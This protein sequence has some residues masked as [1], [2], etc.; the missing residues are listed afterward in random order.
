MAIR[1]LIVAIENYP[2]ASGLAKEL[3]GTNDAARSF[4]NWLAEKKGVQPKGKPGYNRSTFFC[5]ADK[6]VDF[7]TH[8]TTRD[9]IVRAVV[10]LENAAKEDLASGVA[11][12]D[13]LYCFFSGHGLC[14]P[15]NETVQ[16]DLFIASDF[17]TMR[18]S[19]GA[20]VKVTELMDLLRPALGPGDHYYFFDYSRTEV[21]FGEVTPKG[22]GLVF[23]RVQAKLPSVAVLFSVA[24]GLA[25][26]T[27]SGFAKHLVD[28]LSGKGRAKG[29]Y[30][31]DLYV[32]FGFLRE[33]LNRATRNGV[34][35][36]AGSG[37]GLILKI[38]PVPTAPC[39]IKVLDAEPSDYF[40]FTVKQRNKLIVAG[41]FNG[42]EHTVV[43]D[44]PGDY[45]VEVTHR[46]AAVLRVMPPATSLVDLYDA[47]EVVFRKV[48]SR[49]VSPAI[50]GESQVDSKPGI[51]QVVV[52]P[53]AA[54]LERI[55]LPDTALVDA[56]E[57]PDVPF[58]TIP[59]DQESHGT[60]PAAAGSQKVKTTPGATIR[61]QRM[62]A[63]ANEPDVDERIVL[64]RSF[65]PGDYRVMIEQAQQVVALQTINVRAV[66]GPSPLRDALVG[67]FRTYWHGDEFTE[68]SAGPNA[69][70][71]L[72]LWISWIGAARV[73]GCGGGGSFSRLSNAP[74][75]ANFQAVA[76]GRAVLF[77]L[78]G[79]ESRSGPYAIGVGKEPMWSEMTRVEGIE[80]L[81]ELSL[82]VD[83]GPKLLTFEPKGKASVTLSTHALANRATLLVITDNGN[84]SFNVYQ[85]LLPIDALSE[86]PPGQ[87]QWP[88]GSVAALTTIALI[89]GV[90]HQFARACPIDNVL[91]PKQGP[92]DA[93]ARRQFEDLMAAKWLDPIASLIAANDL[94]RRGV[95]ADRPEFAGYRGVLPV[96]VSDFRRLFGA[97]PDL[98]ALARAIKGEW[99]LPTAPPML[100]DS[101][102]AFGPLELEVIMP[103]SQDKLY[104]ETPWVAWTDVVERFYPPGR[105]TPPTASRLNTRKLDGNER[106]RLNEAL[107]D[108]FNSPEQ[109]EKMLGQRM[110]IRLSEWA[111]LTK[112]YDL[113]VAELIDNIQ[114][115][116]KWQELLAAARSENPDNVKLREFAHDLGLA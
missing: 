79:F 104:L 114:A 36:D 51:D 32:N 92:V 57:Q 103:F 64:S 2:N 17:T 38:D 91:Y 101:V 84:R 9:Q 40:A 45:Q 78:A 74:L 3:P 108:A 115:K 26:R 49:T 60:G 90:E 11:A 46:E 110:D 100:R 82:E 76:S 61:V 21:K 39:A 63:P 99:N 83:P 24:Q 106:R 44:E 62:Q 42:A 102:S 23:E 41:K 88:V 30:R 14:Y 70:H 15:R 55:A 81:Y 37:D 96:L 95:M 12:T 7:R 97:T 93:A 48:P 65:P 75:Q 5:C 6:E 66:R 105:S 13:E 85:F 16:D 25:A 58:S 59:W 67:V 94:L 111:T 29:W 19:G 50:P 47:A 1:A 80:G 116:D 54:A 10:S 71:E 112:K 77:V 107:R 27:D 22:L 87:A 113:M 31:G 43:I 86:R 53:R 73:V 33:Y 68:S 20:C 72:G 69:D 35:G 34:E 52:T 89:A 56:H 109:L 8:G 18:K 28:G 4:C 98:E